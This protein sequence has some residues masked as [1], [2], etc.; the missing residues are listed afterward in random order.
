MKK[1]F[2]CLVVFFV[3]VLFLASC[4]QGTTQNPKYKIIFDSNGG[5]PVQTIV[6]EEGE[7]ILMPAVDPQKEGYEFL[8]WYLNGELYR[9]EKMPAEDILLVAKWENFLI[10]L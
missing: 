1:I 5:T 7:D 9:I 6:L 2:N 10:K 4:Q 8:G 3:S